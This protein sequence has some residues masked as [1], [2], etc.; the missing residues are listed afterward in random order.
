M[1]HIPAQGPGT[2]K[3]VD[4][5][6]KA[7]TLR[8]AV[9]EGHISIRPAILRKV[10]ANTV[11][12]GNVLVVSQVAGIMAAKG[13]PRL[14]PL[15]HPIKTVHCAIEFFLEKSGIRARSSITAV[16]KTGAE[17]EA[18]VAV[19]AAL[20]NIYDMLKALDPAMVIGD[21]RLLEKQGGKSGHYI[22]QD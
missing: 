15:C 19:A 8:I 7:D 13:T 6:L 18:L 1:Q 2:V 22:R 20:L 11:P 3:M 9:A 17:M 21:I 5:S 10:R 16:D 12:K 4:V 14:I